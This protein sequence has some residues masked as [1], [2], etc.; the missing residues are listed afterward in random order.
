INWAEALRSDLIAGFYLSASYPAG[1]TPL[2][3]G[4]LMD[5]DEEN[6]AEIF[7]FTMADPSNFHL[8]LDLDGTV[9]GDTD[10]DGNVDDFS[11]PTAMLV[12]GYKAYESGIRSDATAAGRPDFLILKNGVISEFPRELNGRRYEDWDDPGFQDPTIE[13]AAQNYLDIET[14]GNVHAPPLVIINQRDRNALPDLFNPER[15][16]MTMAMAF[17]FGD[18][19]YGH[20]GQHALR[21]REILGNQ[22]PSGFDDW[23]DEMSVDPEGVGCNH[24]AYSGAT[25]WQYSDWMGLPLGPA[26][27]LDPNTKTY[28]RDFENAV[29][30]FTGYPATIDL[31]TQ[32][33]KILGSDDPVFNDGSRLWSIDFPEPESGAIL[34]R[35][36]PVSALCP[37][38][39]TAGC[40]TGARAKITIRNKIADDGD[41]LKWTLKKGGAFT[42]GDLGAPQQ[43]TV[44]LACVYDDFGSSPVLAASL[45]VDPSLAWKSRTPKGYRYKDPA[46][47]QD[48]VRVLHVDA[49][50]EG[51]TRVRLKARGRNLPLPGPAAPGTFFHVDPAVTVQLHAVGTGTCWS[52]SFASA[53][54]NTAEQFRASF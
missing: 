29:A 19:Y 20:T 15:H 37:S 39:P 16:R 31:G 32:F 17:I 36:A 50:A 28:R 47:A 49:G 1:Q 45:R 22:E 40:I 41:R 10:G 51:R 23:L 3:D 5:A 4:I 26:V 53:R 2:C 13:A 7:G 42:Q 12:A 25:R 33:R 38:Q 21:H 27:E 24:P 43:T 46:A 52:S 54:R 48:G 34:M 9:D 14:P 11:I 8:D 35:I 44:Y 6:A 18:G 30:L